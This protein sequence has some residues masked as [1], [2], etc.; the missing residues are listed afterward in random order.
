MAEILGIISSVGAIANIIEATSKVIVTANDIHARWNDIDLTL[1]SFTAQL[2]AFRAALRRVQEWMDNEAQ[3]QHHQL[4]MDL[5][6]TLSCCAA[7]IA[8]IETLFSDWLVSDVR[9]SSAASRWKFVLK[10]KGMDSVLK[11][12]ER[13]TN[14]LTLLL[15]ACNCKTIS[16][17][18][19]LLE[20]PKTR[21]ALQRARADSLSLFVHRD[22]ES[23]RSQVTDNLSKMSLV[24]D[25]DPEIFSSSPY[26][27]VFRG[28]LK[29]FLRQQQP[30]QQEQSLQ[31]KRSKVDDRNVIVLEKVRDKFFHRPSQVAY[32]IS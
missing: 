25:F 4:V 5:E 13:Q 8:R 23:L 2:T 1:L 10:N 16:E 19:G 3:E 28:S 26:H 20:K 17:Q 9:P 32:P 21:S 6:S 15:T 18:Q 14:T 31:E 30:Q 11:L 12:V 29:H 24:F 22:T 7:L 27:R